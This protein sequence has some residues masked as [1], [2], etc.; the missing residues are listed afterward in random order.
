MFRFIPFVGKIPAVGKALTAAVFSFLLW[1]MYLA[2]VPSRP[3]HS[4]RQLRMVAELCR[5]AAA[6]LVA[7]N[8]EHDR[9]VFGNLAGDPFGGVS[10]PLWAALSR[11]ERLQIED[12]PFT[13]KLRERLLWTLP[14]FSPE[15][16]LP[17]FAGR[18][19][20]RYAIG[21]EASNFSD[22]GRQG[23][24]AVRLVLWDASQS[25]KLA[26][27]EFL[28]LDPPPSEKTVTGLETERPP[29]PFTYRL[30]GW[31]IVAGALPLLCVIRRRAFI[32]AGNG[33]LLAM[34]LGLIVVSALLAYL[35]VA[36]TMSPLWGGALMTLVLPLSTIYHAKAL[37][38]LRERL[39]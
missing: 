10:L 37:V 17:E 38:F 5:Q 7:A 9:A 29:V 20:V 8:P 19:H 24:L 16:G 14:T 13:E 15:D 2:V 3:E 21:G 4:E 30:F 28:I 36:R 18:R 6:W 23:R 34:L 11:T 32:Q 22:D 26:E 31:L 39:R 1:Q 33:L 27:K 12:R 25:A 35:F